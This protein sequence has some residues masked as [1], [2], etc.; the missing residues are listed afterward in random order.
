MF[1]HF[2]DLKNAVTPVGIIADK[3][4]DKCG[5]TAKPNFFKT[6]KLHKKFL[7]INSKR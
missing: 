6:E 4:G 1:T 7:P 3:R 5:M 2:F